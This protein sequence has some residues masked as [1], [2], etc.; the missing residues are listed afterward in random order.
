MAEIRNRE[1]PEGPRFTKNLPIEGLQFKYDDEKG[2][3]EGYAAIMGNPDSYDEVIDLGA[4]KRTLRENKGR[5]ALAWQHNFREPIGKPSTLREVKREKLPEEIQ[6]KFPKATGGLH[7]KSR[8]SDTRQGKDAKTLL[9]DG[10]VDEVSIGFDFYDADSF[11]EGDDGYVHLREIMLYECSLVTMAAQPAAQVVSYKSVAEAQAADLEPDYGKPYPNEHACRLRSPDDF[12]DGSFRRTERKHDGKTY[13]VIMGRLE[14]ESTMTEQAYRYP[15]DGWEV[16]EARSH[17]KD[18]DGSFEAASEEAAAIIELI[19]KGELQE[20]S[21]L[22]QQLITELPPEDPGEDTPAAVLGL[23]EE[24]DLR[25]QALE[26]E[27]GEL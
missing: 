10:V 16:G 27:L 4:F 1:Q 2:E 9:R 5:I 11:Y 15:K 24:L 7:F 14:G 22:L 3:V 20:A 23:A 21:E 13:Y 17:C 18:H 6:K 8:I 26:F 12:Q 25:A 19:Q